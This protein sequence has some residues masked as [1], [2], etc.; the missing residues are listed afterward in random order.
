[1]AALGTTPVA[2]LLN[3]PG[4]SAHGLREATA[5]TF[6]PYVGQTFDFREPSPDRGFFPICVRLKLAK[7]TRHENITRIE[8]RDRA[9]YGKRSRESFSLLFELRG[10][11]SLASSLVEIAHEDFRGALI[12]LS[13]VLAPAPDGT[14]FYEAT[15]G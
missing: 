6:E 14:K 10:R 5:D 7:V 13:P 4:R 1:L 12:F 2:H 8:A 9:K 3:F 15:F 11:K